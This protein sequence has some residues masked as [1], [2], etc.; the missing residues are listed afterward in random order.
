MRTINQGDQ[1]IIP[2]EDYDLDD[3]CE[4][5]K[6][7]LEKQ[8]YVIN[9]QVLEMIECHETCCEDYHETVLDAVGCFLKNSTEMSE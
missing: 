6:N 5:I 8:G 1:A 3:R 2:F 9:D 4:M 7:E